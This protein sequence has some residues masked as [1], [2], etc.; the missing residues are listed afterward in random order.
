LRLEIF[1]SNFDVGCSAPSAVQV[2]YMSN[3]GFA[4]ESHA[5][6]EK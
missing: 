5:S 4:I 1:I 2:K 3:L 6:L